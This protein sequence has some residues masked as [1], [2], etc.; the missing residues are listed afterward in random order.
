MFNGCGVW[1]PCVW[2]GWD[3]T[4]L[5]GVAFSQTLLWRLLL[6]WQMSCLDLIP[7]SI[8]IFLSTIYLVS[9]LLWCDQPS[10]LST[11]QSA[12]RGW[13][14]TKRDKGHSS[15]EGK[16]QGGLPVSAPTSNL[17]HP[18]TNLLYVSIHLHILSRLRL[19]NSDG[20]LRPF[21][22]TT[23]RWTAV[24]PREARGEERDRHDQR[25]SWLQ[26]SGIRNRDSCTFLVSYQ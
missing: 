19:I 4:Q 21:L 11:S 26:I 25:R 7:G 23:D 13:H 15:T 18:L 22:I 14:Q 24:A 20:G 10:Y 12:V 5:V 16:G 1:S 17:H 8:W 2:C 9:K 3:V 6:L